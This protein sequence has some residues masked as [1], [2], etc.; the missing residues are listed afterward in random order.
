M[1]VFYY[2]PD[3]CALASHIALEDA[4]AEY[5]LRRIDFEKKEQRSP[6]YLAV[7]PKGRVPALVTSRGVLTET[8]AILAY[9]AQ[10][11]PAAHLA[12]LGDPFAFGQLQ[13]FNSYICSTL[14]VAHAHRMRG[15]RWADEPEAIAAMQRK[16]PES[17]GACYAYI[18]EQAFVGPFVRGENYT[19]ADPY[20]FTV[21]QGM[22]ADGVDPTQ[23]PKVAAHREMMRQRRSVQTAL[24]AECEGVGA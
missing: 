2:A 19:I 13:A 1:L 18:E 11:F 22:E 15:T 12:P 16:V 10:S 7:N 9:V 23:F 8:P 4:G 24:R 6:D 17:V 14:H 20:L 5:R 3:T 21:A